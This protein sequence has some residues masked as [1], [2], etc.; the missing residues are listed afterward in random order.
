MD[1]DPF[2]G[3]FSEL[4]RNQD[5]AL[6]AYERALAANPNSTPALNAV[7]MLLKGRE[8]FDKAL[9]F[10]R[11]IVQLD[12]NNGEAWGNL[13]MSSKSSLRSTTLMSS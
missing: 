5:D 11:L 13:G 6:Q 12:Q 1:V 3:S 9:E 7:G 2:I 8:Q 10:F 4:L